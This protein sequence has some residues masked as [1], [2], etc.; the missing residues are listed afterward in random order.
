MVGLPQR[1]VSTQ[2]A[3]SLIE[4]CGLWRRGWTWDDHEAWHLC[5]FS[6]VFCSVCVHL[7]CVA[8]VC[9]QQKPI[10]TQEHSI[11]LSAVLFISRHRLAAILPWI[12]RRLPTRINN[13]KASVILKIFGANFR[14]I[15]SVH[16]SWFRSGEAQAR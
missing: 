1:L 14:E 10:T 16:R 3:R 2:N 4:K 7:C 13:F 5:V 6:W 12:I 15:I 8:S 9:V 11:R